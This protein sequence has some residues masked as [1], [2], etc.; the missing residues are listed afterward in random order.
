MARISCQFPEHDIKITPGTYGRYAYTESSINQG[1]FQVG[2]DAGIDTLLQ[3][4]Y[5]T[6][7]TR[8]HVSFLIPDANERNPRQTSRESVTFIENE[9][10][11]F[12]MALAQRLQ[13][14]HQYLDDAGNLN[15]TLR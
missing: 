7:E 5:R 3:E 8:L 4:L 1:A 10:S 12:E 9:W 14:D 15:I 13:L 2:V 6:S 11:W